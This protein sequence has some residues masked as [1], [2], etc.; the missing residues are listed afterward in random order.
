MRG[1]TTTRIAALAWAGKQQQAIAAAT[2]ALAAPRLGAPSGWRCSI[3]ASN[4]SPPRGASTMLRAMLPRCWP[5][6]MRAS[7]PRSACRH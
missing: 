7:N 2:E 5:S 4:R 1:D 6:P 3:C